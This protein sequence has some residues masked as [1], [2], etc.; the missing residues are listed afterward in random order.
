M[1]IS[2]ARVIL[3]LIFLAA[4]ILLLVYAQHALHQEQIAA[5]P[6]PFF[7]KV[8]AFFIEVGDWFKGTAVTPP[9]PTHS[10]LQH[11]IA[12]WS[13]AALSA[14]G[15]LLMLFCRKRI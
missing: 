9:P 6:K 7:E 10:H 15:V 13:G 14:I 3:G 1:R 5:G 2:F 4:G 12:L 8:H 11:E